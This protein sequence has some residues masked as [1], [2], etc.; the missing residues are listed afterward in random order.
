MSIVTVQKLRLS[1]GKGLL[2]HRYSAPLRRTSWVVRPSTRVHSHTSVCIGRLRC[3]RCNARSVFLRGPL[4]LILLFLQSFSLSLSLPCRLSLSICISLSLS[5]SLTL[6]IPLATARS[7]TLSR[8]LSRAL[9][10]THIYIIY[11]HIYLSI[12]ILIHMHVYMRIHMHIDIHR[13]WGLVGVYTTQINLGPGGEGSHADVHGVI[14]ALIT[15]SPQSWVYNRT[16]LGFG[17]YGAQINSRFGP[18]WPKSS[19]SNCFAYNR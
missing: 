8:S 9:S 2:S 10:L 18:A 6:S 17:P 3:W 12:H 7:L 1:R 4:T 19:C 15:Q 16:Q 5:L 11:K 14:A 13:W